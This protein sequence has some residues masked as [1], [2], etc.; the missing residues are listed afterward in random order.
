MSDMTYRRL[1][2]SGL[3]V[4]TVGL[5]CNSEP[6]RAAS[7]TAG[8]AF[9]RVEALRAGAEARGLYAIGAI[10]AVGVGLLAW[11]AERAGALPLACNSS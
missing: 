3:H 2:R 6:V 4:L 5:G 10:P 11:R 1:G 9:D 8:D 7:V